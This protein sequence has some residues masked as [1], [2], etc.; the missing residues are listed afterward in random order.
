MSLATS[1]TVLAAAVRV[2][3]ASLGVGAHIADIATAINVRLSTVEDTV[4]A[5]DTT[6]HGATLIT[7]AIVVCNTHTAQRAQWLALSTCASTINI[8]FSTFPQTV[9]AIPGIGCGTHAHMHGAVACFCH[10]IAWLSAMASHGAPTNTVTTT[11]D[12]ELASILH[13]IEAAYAHLP[14]TPRHTI[15]FTHTRD[16]IRRLITVTPLSTT[17]T[18]SSTIHICLAVPHS[19][20]LCKDSQCHGKQR[21]NRRWYCI[22]QTF[23]CC[24]AGQLTGT[25]CRRSRYRFPSHSELRLNTQD[26]RRQQYIC[27]GRHSSRL[28]SRSP[29][30]RCHQ[31]GKPC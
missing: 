26:P 8:G 30:C 25:I 29:R 14:W 16:T 24:T 18:A 5:A 13:P 9:R 6:A 4:T 31:R 23:D 19:V 11:V 7:I 1:R 2:S 3:I 20:H 21:D 22:V 10:T 28:Y 17:C 15:D 27:L 12:I